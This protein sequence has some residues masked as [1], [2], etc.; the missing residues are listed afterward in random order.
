VQWML[1]LHEV[2]VQLCKHFLQT[3][4]NKQT[5]MESTLLCHPFLHHLHPICEIDSL[6]EISRKSISLA[7]GGSFA[8]VITITTITECEQKCE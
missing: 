5:N 6:K 3:Q 1:V 4:D 2:S 7:M 8:V